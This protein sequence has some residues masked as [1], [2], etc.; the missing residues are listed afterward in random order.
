M[1]LSALAMGAL[2]LATATPAMA[3]DVNGAGA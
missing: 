3:G 2:A 1:K